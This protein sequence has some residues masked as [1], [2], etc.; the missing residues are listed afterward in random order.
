[1]GPH[2]NFSPEISV[3]TVLFLSS[4]FAIGSSHFK[5]VSLRCCKGVLVA[6]V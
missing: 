4:S 6:Y 2:S 5:A 1:M 3:Q